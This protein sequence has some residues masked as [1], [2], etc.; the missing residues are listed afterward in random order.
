MRLAITVTHH[1]QLPERIVNSHLFILDVNSPEAN[2]RQLD[3]SQTC[4]VDLTWNERGDAILV[5]GRILQLV[6]G[7]TCTVSPAPREYPGLS[8]HY[9]TYQALWLDSDHVIR[10]NGEIVDLSCS[11][12]ATQAAPTCQ[13]GEV[14]QP[15]NGTKTLWPCEP[16]RRLAVGAEAYCFSTYYPSAQKTELHCRGI[17]GDSEIPVPKQVREYRVTQAA[18]SSGR[19]IA[20]KWEQPHKP[21]WEVLFFWWVPDAGSTPLPRQR[22]VF[23]LSAGKLISSWKPRIQ[24]SNSPHVEDWPHH[25]TISGNGELVAESGDGGLE[26]YR[27]AP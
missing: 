15:L 18:H 11:E 4:G 17:Q 20:D 6:G 1:Q 12:V 27:L 3:L 22:V 5:C 7:S 9:S 13:I 10:R 19:F 24:V 23:D 25:C 14:A 16:Q 21:W 26:V 8:R 2:V